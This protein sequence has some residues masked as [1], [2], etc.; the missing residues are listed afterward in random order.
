VSEQ[1]IEGMA[2]PIAERIALLR[3]QSTCA[4]GKSAYFL[5]RSGGLARDTDVRVGDG[6]GGI[7][8]VL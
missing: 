6:V 8:R 4:A 2:H 7:E 3:K 1:A 5:H